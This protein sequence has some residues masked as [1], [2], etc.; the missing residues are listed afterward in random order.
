LCG[1]V[2]SFVSVISSSVLLR[3]SSASSLVDRQDINGQQSCDETYARAESPVIVQYHLAIHESAFQL[4]GRAEFTAHAI[5]DLL[6]EI[7][8]NFSFQ[9]SHYPYLRYLEETQWASTITVAASRNL[10]G[11]RQLGDAGL[12]HAAHLS[13]C[14]CHPDQPGSAEAF[15]VMYNP[16]RKESSSARGVQGLEPQPVF[17][18]PLSH[19]YIQMG[20]FFKASNVVLP[21]KVSIYRQAERN[22]GRHSLVEHCVQPFKLVI[23]HRCLRQTA[24]TAATWLPERPSYVPGI[25]C[26]PIRVDSYR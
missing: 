4:L 3:A 17:I 6:G 8:G 22:S 16:E 13:S 1:Q 10:F 5:A 20:R 7:P 19:C 25:Q 9:Q 21:L 14:Q 15:Y 2:T 26:R 23:E 24:E 11:Q 18:Y 12:A